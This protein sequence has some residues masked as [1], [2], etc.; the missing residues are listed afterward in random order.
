MVLEQLEREGVGSEVVQNAAMGTG[1]LKGLGGFA[2][3]TVI[4]A[5]SQ[6]SG[7]RAMAIT[8]AVLDIVGLQLAGTKSE[9]LDLCWVRNQAKREL[10][11][12]LAEEDEV[13]I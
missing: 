6:A 7:S 2:D 9:H 5:K 8:K 3:D 10:S 1:A 11:H 4:L 13:G 12:P